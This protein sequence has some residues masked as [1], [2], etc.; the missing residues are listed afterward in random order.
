MSLLSRLTAC[1]VCIASGILL[2]IAFHWAGAM[3]S[4][5]LPMHIPVLI[6]GLFL[7]AKA[8]I[9]T[10]LLTPL[11]SSLTT[12]MPPVMPTLPLMVVELSIYGLAS[13]FF[14]QKRH[15]PLLW[16][17]TTAMLLGRFAA[18]GMSYCLSLSLGI[19]LPPITYLSGAFITGLPGII[20]QVFLIP[21]FV[22]RLQT[23]FPKFAQK[24]EVYE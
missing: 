18:C 5:F 8:G 13:G 1:S 22:K 11:L 6:A 16:A 20:L 2:P 15:L 4:V 12:G 23:A 21:F 19:K 3:G 17:L 14:Y 10:G 9:F 7:G 24:G